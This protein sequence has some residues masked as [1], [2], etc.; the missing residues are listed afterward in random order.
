MLRHSIASS[1]VINSVA[2]PVETQPTWIGAPSKVSMCILS[3]VEGRIFPVRALTHRRA[4]FRSFTVA[5]AVLAK[6]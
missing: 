6:K 2:A 1:A 3:D 4:L 5:A